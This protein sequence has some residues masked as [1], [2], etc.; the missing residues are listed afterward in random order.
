VGDSIIHIFT[1]LKDEFDIIPI[2]KPINF[3]KLVKDFYSSIIKTETEKYITSANELSKLLIIPVIEKIR[4]KEKIVIISHDLLLKIPFEALF[5]SSQKKEIN[6]YSKFDYL[7]KTFDVSY[8]Y[9][10]TLYIN[11]LKERILAETN[12]NNLE[13]S[14]IGFAPVFAKDDI[15]GYTLASN[16]LA[17][18]SD[19]LDDLMRSVIIDG[20]KFN[21]LK[22]SEWEV[23]SIIEL[24]SDKKPNLAYFYSDA[25]EESFKANI[26]NYHIIHTASHSF[27]NENHPQISGIVFAQPTDTT[28][29]DDGILYAGEIYNLDLSADLVVLSSC[30]SGLGKLVRGEGMMALTRGF[31]YSGAANI[32]FSLWKIPDKQTS[33]LM[34]EFY[35]QMLSGKSYAE[36]L[37]Q[38]KLNLIKNQVTTRPRSWASFVLIGSD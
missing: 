22:Y 23:K 8:H 33:E 6:D 12:A 29:P 27:V 31:L 20:K 18:L 38:A 35:K 26:R 9:S 11:N 7:I 2:K 30:E 36:A 13:K 4:S 15:T 32:I 1:V 24:F 17:I 19:G 14:F 28:S 37:R 5:T 10:S 3:S 25:T 21:E 16:E 34:I